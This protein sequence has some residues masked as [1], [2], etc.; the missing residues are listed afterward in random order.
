[1]RYL[2]VGADRKTGQ[3]RQLILN[4]KDREAAARDAIAAGMVVSEVCDAPIDTPPVISTSDIDW[5]RLQRVIT[6]GVCNGVLR[7]L[8]IYILICAGLAMVAWFIAGLISGG[9]A[10]SN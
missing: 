2:V 7:A 5:T 8:L 4:A 3:D 6:V 9:F 1:M 10:T